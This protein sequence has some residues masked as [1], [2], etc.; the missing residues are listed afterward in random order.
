VRLAAVNELGLVGDENV[1]PPLAKALKDS[2]VVVRTAAVGAMGLIGG[3]AAVRS[4]TDALFDGAAPVRRSAA[5][6]LGALRSPDSLKSLTYAVRNEKDPAVL[7]SMAAA[8]G[9]IGNKAG[10]PALMEAASRA[11]PKESDSLYAAQAAIMK[12]N[13]N[14]PEAPVVKKE[15]PPQVSTGTIPAAATASQPTSPATEAKRVKAAAPP[16]KSPP[17]SKP[18]AA[19]TPVPPTK[20][21]VV[22]RKV[23]PVP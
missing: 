9:E 1:V 20:K 16:Q 8:L 11:G 2:D 21:P 4:L 10:M 13:R 18:A 5:V 12:N 23:T 6:A 15:E 3:N 22:K 14:K 19:K 7:S 17:A